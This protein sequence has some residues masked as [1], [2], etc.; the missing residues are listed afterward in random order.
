MQKSYIYTVVAFLKFAPE[1]FNLI[2]CS[3]IITAE[4]KSRKAV[5][6]LQLKIIN[7]QFVLKVFSIFMALIK[8]D[9]YVM[10]RLALERKETR[11]C[12]ELWPKTRAKIN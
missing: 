2:Y 11:R 3:F 7:K 12:K 10:T 1:S 4:G 5:S 8:L 6:S 9:A